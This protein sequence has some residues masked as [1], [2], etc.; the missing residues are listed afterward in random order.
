MARNLYD[1]ACNVWNSTLPRITKCAPSTIHSAHLDLV[2][3]DDYFKHEEEHQVC[4][5][6]KNKR[7]VLEPKQKQSALVIQRCYHDV[8]LRHHAKFWEEIKEQTLAYCILHL[9]HRKAHYQQISTAASTI[10]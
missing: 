5:F 9:A 7:H 4:N 3:C 6:Y 2:A 10:Q 8:L 1:Y